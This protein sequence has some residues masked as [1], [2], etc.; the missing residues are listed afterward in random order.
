MFLCKER[1]SLGRFWRNSQNNWDSCKH[2]LGGILCTAD[3]EF[4]KC[5]KVI[6]LVAEVKQVSHYTSLRVTH[7]YWRALS[8]ELHGDLPWTR[9]GN[10]ENT[11]RFYLHRYTVH[12]IET[13]S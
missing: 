6:H 5:G 12:F 3:K 4:R 1:L 13:F 9:S 10:T 11:Y 7:D 2:P 8:E